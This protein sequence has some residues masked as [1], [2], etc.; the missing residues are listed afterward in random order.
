MDALVEQISK[1]FTNLEEDVSK[2][3][4]GKKISFVL[5]TEACSAVNNLVRDA[6]LLIG[7]A[8]YTSDLDEKAE[9]YKHMTAQTIAQIASQ[10]NVKRL[11]L[12]HFSQRY[13]SVDVI[14]ED[15]R[16]V[17]PDTICAFDFMQVKW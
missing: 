7:E 10:E 13:K 17:F 6:D 4:E 12:T 3:K 2:I 9:E 1:R 14:E 15:A 5:D 8:T 11:I 16:K